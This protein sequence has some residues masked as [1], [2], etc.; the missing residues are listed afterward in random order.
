LS[1]LE[2]TRS[3]IA[4]LS[5]VISVSGEISQYLDSLEDAWRIYLNDVTVKLEEEMIIYP[6]YWR[7]HSQNLLLKKLISDQSYCLM[8][9]RD[10]ISGYLERNIPEN[11]ARKLSFPD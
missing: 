10:S 5:S 8:K 7:V 3:W 11:E 4:D 2:L 6:G 9:E 1:Q